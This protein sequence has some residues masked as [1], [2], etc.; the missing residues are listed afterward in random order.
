[1]IFSAF[2]LFF[3][4]HRSKNQLKNLSFITDFKF[5]ASEL[6]KPAEAGKAI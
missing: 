3:I 4:F 1:M 6:K 2:S 5:S